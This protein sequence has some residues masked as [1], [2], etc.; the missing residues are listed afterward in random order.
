M[1]EY[2][3]QLPS[4]PTKQ[5]KR[6]LKCL[7][8]IACKTLTEFNF[9]R[10]YLRE[11]KQHS[12]AV[13]LLTRIDETEVCFPGSHFRVLSPPTYVGILRLP[14][15]QPFIL[16]VPINLKIGQLPR[17]A[18][19]VHLMQLNFQNVNKE[20]VYLLSISN[21]MLPRIENDSVHLL[22]CSNCPVFVKL[23][24]S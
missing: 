21:I 7:E 5:P 8:N 9:F 1:I 20:I 17:A 22:L 15:C 13:L 10:V 14:H 3:F 18:V 12:Q 4:R 23:S 19:L 11:A 24:K 16:T 2:S 6:N